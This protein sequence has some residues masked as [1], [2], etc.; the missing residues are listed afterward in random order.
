MSSTWNGSSLQSKFAAKHGFSGDS[1]ALVRV[2]DWVNDIQTDIA[3]NYGWPNLKFRMKKQVVSGE[4]EIDISP[5]IPSAAT[6]A[7]LAG[8]SITAGAVYVKV[9]FLLFDETGL[10]INSLESEASVA[11][12]TVTTAAGDLSIT[13]T[14]LDLYD[15]SATVKPTVI[16][17]RIY[18]KLGT[19]NYY[20]AKTITDNTTTTTT[21]TTVTTSV[22]EPPE[23]SLVSLMAEEDIIIESS[24]I[25]LVQAKLDDILKSD[26]AISSTGLPQNYSRISPTK[27]FLYP[28]PSSTYTLTYWVYKIPCRIFVD[29]DRPIQLHHA[30]KEVLDAGMT[31]KGYE[32]KDSDGQE[33]KR[34]NYENRKKEAKGIIGRTGAQALTV[35]VVF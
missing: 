30:L 18:L 2:L 9:T 10:E 34:I 16:H 20:L 25:S 22:V 32:Y 19:G 3:A 4:Q 5:Q 28:R 24:G 12:N 33:S 17:R 6:I 15:G 14:N 7:L 23:Y 26:P 8:G 35:K 29:T 11:S 27:V 21:I 1:A 13:I 31:W